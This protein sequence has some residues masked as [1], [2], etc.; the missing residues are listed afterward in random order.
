MD[1][2]D[3][4][5]GMVQLEDVLAELRKVYQRHSKDPCVETP[6]WSVSK[7]IHTW[8]YIRIREAAETAHRAVSTSSEE[9]RTL[10][11]RERACRSARSEQASLPSC[12]RPAGGRSAY[13]RPCRGSCRIESRV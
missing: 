8:V 3:R 10:R 7:T 12:R 13:G 11:L 4:K 5:G 9:V 1:T 6:R 2:P